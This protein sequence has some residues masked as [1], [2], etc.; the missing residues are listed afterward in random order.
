[1]A[2][3]RPASSTPPAP[4]A[5]PKAPSSPTTTSPPTPSPCSPAGRS[6]RPTVSCS[7]CPSFTS[8][9]SATDCTAGSPAAA[10]CACWSASSI[11]RPPPSFL[12]FRPT[13]FFGVPTIYVR[14][15]EIP[16][17]AAREIGAAMRLFVSGSAPLPAQVLE[18]FRARFGHTILERYGM[19]E[20]LMNISNPYLGERRPGSVGLPLPGVS[21]RLVD[22]EIHL[23]GPQPLRRLLASRRGHPR[24]LRRRLV[25]H[26]RSRRVRR[27]TATTR[28][29][30]ARATSS[31]PAASTSIRARSR[32]SCRNSRKSPKP[33]SSA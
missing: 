7:R 18:E 6:P 32:S 12:D 13:L 26:R 14:L 28:S 30:A 1:M 8:T 24:R 31:F 21:V 22:G 33:P 9:P 15:L 2:T 23:K 17:E 11:R 5:R 25:P 27:P 19:S 3:H 29:P 4:P 10:A 20:N 16:A